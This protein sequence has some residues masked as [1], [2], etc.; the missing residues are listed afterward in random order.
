MAK[1]PLQL[2]DDAVVFSSA[3]PPAPLSWR[4]CG[5]F[6]YSLSLCFVFVGGVFRRRQLFMD[7][8]QTRR[9][10]ASNYCV[11]FPTG[12]FVC[13]AFRINWCAIRSRIFLSLFSRKSADPATSFANFC[14]TGIINH[15]RFARHLWF[16]RLV[17]PVCSI[18]WN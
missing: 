13:T 15:F 7:G 14:F 17:K 11:Q 12:F 6:F 9:L 4:K 2:I 10:F 8:F 1:S 16:L 3:F 18:L 5:Y